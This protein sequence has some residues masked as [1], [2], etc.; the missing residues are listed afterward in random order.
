[1][2]HA[3]YAHLVRRKASVGSDSGRGKPSSRQSDLSGGAYRFT[4]LAK[5]AR[6]LSLAVLAILP[7]WSR[8]SPSMT[9]RAAARARKV[10]ASSWLIRREYPATSAAKIAASR[11][12]ILCSFGGCTGPPLPVAMVLRARPG[13]KQDASAREATCRDFSARA[14]NIAPHPPCHIRDAH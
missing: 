11:R 4:V 2:A 5:S 9:S 14:C 8:I 1:M 3:L 7:P 10:P 13:F 12:S 6:T